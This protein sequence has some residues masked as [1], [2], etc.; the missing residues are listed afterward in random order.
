M[1]SSSDQSLELLVHTRVYNSRCTAFVCT[2]CTLCETKKILCL[3]TLSH[4]HDSEY[5][6]KG[7]SLFRKVYTVYRQ[8]LYTC[9]CKPW[10]TLTNHMGR[11]MSHVISMHR[12]CNP[13]QTAVSDLSKVILC[14]V[15]PSFEH[16]IV[17]VRAKQYNHS[18]I[19]AKRKSKNKNSFDILVQG[20][21]R[22]GTTLSHGIFFFFIMKKCRF[23]C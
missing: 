12:S 15:A 18:A 1:Q 2:L 10:Y 17:L 14:L 3:Y 7:F 16:S 21:E 20:P 5:T 13:R 8:R 19:A 6:N 4:H 22:V 11:C 23:F 9:Y